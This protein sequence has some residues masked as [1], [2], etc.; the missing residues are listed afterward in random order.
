MGRWAH[1]GGFCVDGLVRIA[2]AARAKA[3]VGSAQ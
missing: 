1:S 3:K 2:A